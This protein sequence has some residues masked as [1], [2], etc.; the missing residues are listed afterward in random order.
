LGKKI[1]IRDFVTGCQLVT[2]NGLAVTEFNT[3]HWT[4]I[5]END[6]VKLVCNSYILQNAGNTTVIIGQA[7]TLF[8][9]GVLAVGDGASHNVFNDE[10]NIQFGNTNY[11]CEVDDSGVLMPA[12]KRLEIIYTIPND[13]YLTKANYQSPGTSHNPRRY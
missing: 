9:N 13:P 6:D 1:G 3:K 7:W 12:R 4:P 10:V 5:T 8:P 2:K 11:A